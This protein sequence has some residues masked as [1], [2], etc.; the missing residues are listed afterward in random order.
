MNRCSFIL[1]VSGSIHHGSVCEF[2]NGS[3]SLRLA[4]PGFDPGSSSSEEFSTSRFA[5]PGFDP[6]ARTGPSS[7]SLVSHL[8]SERPGFESG[9]GPTAIQRWRAPSELAQQRRNERRHGTTPTDVTDADGRD[10]RRREA[11]ATALRMVSKKCPG[12]PTLKCGDKG[13]SPNKL[14]ARSAMTRV[15]YQRGLVGN[16]APSFFSRNPGILWV[17]PWESRL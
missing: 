14:R 11:A 13:T 12:K 8:R 10:R 9:F 5:Q 2:L 7:M 4:R 16:A 1:Q 6:A 17:A 15:T 3:K